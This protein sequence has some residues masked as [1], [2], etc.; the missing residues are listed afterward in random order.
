MAISRSSSN[1]GTRN[2]RS[3]TFSWDHYR[4]LDCFL[5]AREFFK[6]KVEYRRL[7]VIELSPDVVGTFDLVFCAGL[8]Y[9]VEDPLVALKRLR[10][11]TKEQLILETNSLIPALHESLPQITLHPGD[12]QYHTLANGRH[13][14]TWKERGYYHAGAVPTQAWVTCGLEL[15]GFDRCDVVATPSFRWLKKMVALATNRAQKGR[16]IVHAFVDPPQR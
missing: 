9:H 2:V 3:H 6:S 15:A 4:G 8:L 12:D 7:D 14:A 11:V 1:G 13:D 10:S 16:L 5:A